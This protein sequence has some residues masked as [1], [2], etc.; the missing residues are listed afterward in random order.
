[1]HRTRRIPSSFRQEKNALLPPADQ[2]ANLKESV[3]ESKKNQSR[4][5]SPLSSP[6]LPTDLPTLP[7]ASTQ[8]IVVDL[9]SESDRSSGSDDEPFDLLCVNPQPYSYSCPMVSDYTSLTPLIQ[10]DDDGTSTEEERKTNARR[11]K[12]R[13]IEGDSE[14]AT[15][16][17]LDGMNRS[18]MRR[19]RIDSSFILPVG[20]R[21]PTTVQ[22]PSIVPLSANRKVIFDAASQS[23]IIPFSPD[24]FTSVL[25][26][27]VP[28]AAARRGRPPGRRM[29]NRTTPPV[30]NLDA[31]MPIGAMNNKAG[32]SSSTTE[33][34]NAEIL[35]KVP[36]VQT[37]NHDGNQKNFPPT[38]P[39]RNMSKVGVQHQISAVPASMMNAGNLSPSQEIAWKL[40]A[41]YSLR[42]DPIFKQ[43]LNAPRT[44]NIPT[45]LFQRMVPVHVPG[46]RVALN[47][48]TGNAKMPGVAPEHIETVTDT[49]QS[50]QNDQR[51]PGIA[52]STIVSGEASRNVSSG[53]GLT[54]GIF[55]TDSSAPKAEQNCFQSVLGRKRRMSGADGRVDG[56]KRREVDVGVSICEIDAT[57]LH[58]DLGRNSAGQEGGFA[59][60]VDLNVDRTR[61]IVDGNMS[62]A[63][64]IGALRNPREVGDGTHVLREAGNGLIG[65]EIT[66]GHVTNVALNGAIRMGSD[67]ASEITGSLLQ[68]NVNINTGDNT[69]KFSQL[70]HRKQEWESVG[71]NSNLSNQGLANIRDVK[72][73]GNVPLVGGS[74]R[75]DV[76]TQNGRESLSMGLKF[77]S[78]VGSG[79]GM[80]IGLTGGMRSRG[81]AAIESQMELMSSLNNRAAVNLAGVPS[82]FIDGV[83]LG[84][85]QAAM[86]LAPNQ[87]SAGSSNPTM[88]MMMMAMKQQE[89]ARPT[90]DVPMVVPNVA[91]S[92]RQMPSLGPMPM[93]Q[94]GM[95]VGPQS[96]PF[97]QIPIM[98]QNNDLAA[99]L[100]QQMGQNVPLTGGMI[101]GI[102]NGMV[103]GIV[104]NDLGRTNDSGSIDIT[105]IPF[106]V[107]GTA[108]SGSLNSQGI[109]L[110]S[111][112]TNLRR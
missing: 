84:N 41:G 83:A 10:E 53:A 1:M 71:A 59:M 99:N 94:P 100:M 27:Q 4:K 102:S 111:D 106:V 24:D 51:R 87:L 67:V 78:E 82:G 76:D 108:V 65:D 55:N 49:P 92:V 86:S 103:N 97:S 3:L 77:P 35:K 13:P 56:P 85:V 33:I 31:T 89:Q 37:V 80:N 8:S 88:M 74:S 18:I 14:V 90:L 16:V 6:S 7:T 19:L 9:Y 58:G 93:A 104:S 30:S 17:D 25:H 91:M 28:M 20:S 45:G 47:A 44:H 32:P 79:V 52:D 5:L 66:F 12:T 98:V 23:N 2:P 57:R 34:S 11:V 107:N 73:T 54:N 72:D 63:N 29:Q 70:F 26:R 96:I 60:D 42:P 22:I 48:V 61:G 64:S 46:V 38:V 101:N 68:H 95:N 112:N 43:L 21:K 110:L 69:A 50:L 39:K 62:C 75:A 36:S 81:Q 105:G 40:R 109:N 15:S